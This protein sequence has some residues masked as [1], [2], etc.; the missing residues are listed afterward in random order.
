MQRRCLQKA[1]NAA[2][3]FMKQAQSVNNTFQI[4]LAH[5]VAGMIA[6]EEKNYQ[7]AILHF[8]ESNLQNPYNLYRMAVVYEKAGDKENAK[9]FC[10]RAVNDNTLN[11]MQYAFVRHTAEKMLEKM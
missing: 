3:E 11:S 5:E 6:L 7:D 10:E 1:R 4:W 9:D 2:A 8:E